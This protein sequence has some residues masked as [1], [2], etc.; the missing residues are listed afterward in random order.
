MTTLSVIIPTR[1][2]ARLTCGLLDS[3]AQ[4]PA[5]PWKWEVIVMDNGS[6]DDTA[7]RVKQKQAGLPIDIRYVLE[8]RP[9]LHEGRNRGAVEARGKYLAYL[10]D[11][12][13]LAPTW[14]QGVD[15]LEEGKADAV[16]G[17]IVPKWEAPPPQWLTRMFE[18]GVFGP[19]ALLD[20]GEFPVKTGHFYGCNL[21]LPRQT[22]LDF[23]GFHPD[24]MPKELLQ[25]RGDGETGLWLKM[26][27]AGKK[28][29]YAP[30]AIAYHIVPASRMTP[31]YMRQRACNQ[32]VSQSFTDLRRQHGLYGNPPEGIARLLL[33]A[34]QWMRSQPSVHWLRHLLARWHAQSDVEREVSGVRY[35]M[36]RGMAAGWRFH[37]RALRRDPALRAHV[38]RPSFMDMPEASFP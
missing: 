9:G 21:F 5:V 3:L 23:G 22:V 6:T 1:N 37:R 34:K 12:M 24:G 35:E 36:A 27:A 7:E 31:E 29:W 25:Y 15:L 16:V 32:G 14:L 30:E 20:L 4:L 33:G 18:S 10:D 28:L 13:V 8:P 17:R 11:D 26:K 38:L 19:L 2:R